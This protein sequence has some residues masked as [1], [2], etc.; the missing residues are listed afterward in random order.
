MA[1]SVRLVPGRHARGRRGRK[2]G[3]VRAGRIPQARRD[4]ERSARRAGAPMRTTP[5]L[6]MGRGTFSCA[7]AA[8]ERSVTHAAC[9]R[10]PSHALAALKTRL[11]GRALARALRGAA[12]S[13]PR[14]RTG[15]SEAAASTSGA[16]AR[17]FDSTKSTSSPSPLPPSERAR[18]AGRARRRSG[19][20]VRS[21]REASGC[22][23]RTAGSAARAAGAPQ[24]C[25]AA[26]QQPR[27]LA[28]AT[29]GIA[30]PVTRSGGASADRQRPR[31][32]RAGGSP[33][34]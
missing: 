34:D 20:H 5:V 11:A 1:H 25:K 7:A 8:R 3:A 15:T 16:T 6:A 19:A 26:E 31:G 21:A 27:A 14:G 28:T 29:A 4:K 13:R 2:W 17:S 24:R 22:S 10:W 33:L 30:A 23:R 9:G 32:E 12:A 18:K